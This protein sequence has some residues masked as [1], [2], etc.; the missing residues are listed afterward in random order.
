MFE[1]WFKKEL[2]EEDMMDAIIEGYETSTE[3]LK[4]LSGRVSPNLHGIMNFLAGMS[5][6]VGLMQKGH[7]TKD[8]SDA[9]LAA[10]QSDITI[11]FKNKQ[12]E[13]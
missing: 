1:N 8:I 6:T 5:M 3:N 7:M 9:D 13:S 2:S 12:N 10:F 11:R 4:E